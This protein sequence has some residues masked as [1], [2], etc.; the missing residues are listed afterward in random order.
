[1]S[2]ASP[3]SRDDLL[4][5]MLDV[6]AFGS[7]FPAGG[8]PS[9]VMGRFETSDVQEFEHAAAAVACACAAR[10]ADSLP[11]ELRLRC[12]GAG[13]A[14]AQDQRRVHS[15]A[16]RQTPLRFTPKRSERG[17]HARTGSLG[18]LAAAACLLVAAVA[19]WPRGAVETVTPELQMATLIETAEDLTRWDWASWDESSG[20]DAY[21]GVTGEVVWS[22]DAQEGY[23]VLDGMP[24]NNPSAE[25]YQLWVVESSRGAPLEVPP[26]DGGVFD[27]NE[28]GKV[29]IPI[30]VALPASDVVAFAVTVERPGGVV[31]SDQARRV[32]IA[33]DPEQD[34]A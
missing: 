32:V 3:Y 23:M 26:V 13:R 5:Q 21:A 14:V 11:R 27:I 25:Q 10:E 8:S 24:T 18:W 6:V 20:G 31:V 19:T 15:A 33:A 16:P 34:E 2:D 28:A 12:A 9:E 29:V 17:A 7:A 30:R 4:D 22:E 1:M